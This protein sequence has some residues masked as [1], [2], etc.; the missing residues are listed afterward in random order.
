MSTY[1]KV[2]L[3]FEPVVLLFSI[4]FVSETLEF[5]QMMWLRKY[6]G[7][8]PDRGGSDTKF[9]FLKIFAYYKKYSNISM[10][11]ASNVQVL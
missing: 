6:V 3:D 2:K 4:A 7:M 5:C 10:S 11:V 8:L 9:L 1:Q